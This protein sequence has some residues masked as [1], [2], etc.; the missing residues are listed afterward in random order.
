MSRRPIVIAHRGASGHRPE[1]GEA[2]YR[3]AVAQ[4][5]DAI[6]PD[7]VS[8]RDG[9]LILRHE[10]EISGTT[11][12]ADHASFADR[13]TTKEIDGVAV[14]G[15]F[16]EDFT[17]AELEG[18]RI[19]ERLPHLRPASAAH[20]GEGRIQ[21]LADLLA[22]LDEDDARGRHDGP[23]G[24]VAEI[25]HA[26][27]FASIGLPLDELVAAEFARA[28]WSDDPRL[29]VESFESSVLMELG[30]RGVSGR[31]VY[32]L[33]KAGAPFDLV[34]RD[35]SAAR[36][37][38]EQLEPA[39]LADLARRAGL[40]GISLDKKMLIDAAGV[41]DPALVDRAHALGLDVFTWTLRP[42]NAFVSRAL[43][44]SGDKAE[45]GDW[46]TELERVAATGVD[47]VFADYPD[48]VVE[49]LGRDALGRGS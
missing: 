14:T 5:A 7:I 9:V 1:H 34:A 36:T 22:I 49:A 12:V 29:T 41:A 28:G 26:T 30:D 17:W 11:D 25:K 3:L 48:L 2:A 45:R 46:R 47:G 33:E 38:R 24:L 6:E 35:G 16:T 44:T 31:R 40:D 10:N 21:R 39:A 15:W 4:G 32:L 19:R 18:L 8:T 43:R 42:E 20:D 13:R 37:Y 23:V 27:Y